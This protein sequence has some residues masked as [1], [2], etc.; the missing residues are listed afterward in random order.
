MFVEVD[1]FSWTNW[2]EEEKKVDSPVHREQ[3]LGPQIE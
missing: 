2:A 3:L 1:Q